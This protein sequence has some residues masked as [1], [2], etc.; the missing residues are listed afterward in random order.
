MLAC[1]DFLSPPPLNGCLM[2]GSNVTQ[3]LRYEVIL[4]IESRF[5][6]FSCNS[7]VVCN[8][9]YAM[10]CF[11]FQCFKDK[12]DGAAQLLN[13]LKVP[14]SSFLCCASAEDIGAVPDLF[15]LKYIGKVIVHLLGDEAMNMYLGK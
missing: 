7:Y 15:L 6:N 5:K 10:Y 2:I 3:V 9:Y 12:T 4:K 11:V 14:V 13:Y 1:C 8:I